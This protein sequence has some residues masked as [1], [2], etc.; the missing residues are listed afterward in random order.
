[1][2][3]T[4]QRVCQ[5]LFPNATLLE[6]EQALTMFRM[7]LAAP[8][9]VPQVPSL[10]HLSLYR[11]QVMYETVFSKTFMTQFIENGM[12]NMRW[13]RADTSFIANDKDS[14]SEWMTSDKQYGIVYLKDMSQ[15]I[16]VFMQKRKTRVLNPATNEMEETTGIKIMCNGN[17]HLLVLFESLA[18]NFPKL[19]IDNVNLCCP[20]PSR[21]H[22]TALKIEN[23]FYQW[24][25]MMIVLCLLDPQLFSVEQE[26]P[27]DPRKF[28]RTNIQVLCESLC[29]LANVLELLFHLYMF[30]TTSALQPT[31]P[32][33]MYYR[34]LPLTLQQTHPEITTSF[35]ELEFQQNASQKLQQSV[36]QVF[37]TRTDVGEALGHV[38]HVVH[39]LMQVRHYTHLLDYRGEVEFP[40]PGPAFVP[41][42]YQITK[43]RLGFLLPDASSLQSVPPLL[44]K[45][46]FS[47]L[48]SD[49]EG[50]VQKE[51]VDE[52]TGEK[53][54]LYQ[55]SR[56]N[57]VKPLHYS[58]RDIIKVSYTDSKGVTINQAF[59]RSS[60]AHYNIEVEGL[61][62][63]Q[64]N[65]GVN[66]GGLWCP[67]DG[68]G[69]Y[70]SLVDM[71][72]PFPLNGATTKQ[73]NDFKREFEQ[74]RDSGWFIKVCRFKKFSAKY[75]DFYSHV[76]ADWL[77]EYYETKYDCKPDYDSNSQ[78][79][80]KNYDLNRM[81]NETCVRIMYLLA[82]YNPFWCSEVGVKLVK[83][84]NLLRTVEVPSLPTGHDSTTY[85][86]NSFISTF[87]SQNWFDH[88]TDERLDN[89][90]KKKRKDRL[91]DLRRGYMTV[92][93]VNPE[94]GQPEN[95][96]VL[97]CQYFEENPDDRE[98]ESE[99]CRAIRTCC[100]RLLETPYFTGDDLVEI[101]GRYGK[102]YPKVWYL[103]GTDS[104]SR[105]KPTL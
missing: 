43:C 61:S 89:F 39:Q 10:Q 23:D 70:E 104:F 51:Y 46:T 78:K 63:E 47:A 57:S 7:P 52:S 9:E 85:E 102:S 37:G 87:I 91:Y 94:S 6:V 82:P 96:K 98:P 28:L 36:A 74:F 66:T 101:K 50:V 80:N 14:F 34:L 100:K 59:Y 12:A 95:L 35:L 8:T 18:D 40:I 75:C 11:C 103:E 27:K 55:L 81:G 67:V 22:T 105:V 16:L 13:D 45:R 53:L 64:M 68:M 25:T 5:L 65:E 92:D 24:K 42:L 88:T 71:L 84:L 69:L 32:T 83:D 31:Y 93:F 30:L 79:K 49:A 58:G 62:R 1:M 3:A 2:S 97:Y 90:Y 54:V 20:L 29:S 86:V 73:V 72:V 4:L 41:T 76:D 33:T 77:E 99:K 26:V 60:G 44:Q 38:G 56:D 48:D 15:P 21:V 19:S 17:S